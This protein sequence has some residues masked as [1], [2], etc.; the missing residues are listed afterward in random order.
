MPSRA[1][2]ISGEWNGADTGEAASPC[3]R[4]APWPALDRALDRLAMAGDHGLARSVVVGHGADLRRRRRAA[5]IS[6]DQLRV[7]AEEG[8]HGADADRHRLLHQLAAPAHQPHRVGEVES[9]RR[10]PAPSTRRGCARRPRRARSPVRL[11]HAVDGDR[12]GQHRRL[13]VG[14][15]LELGVRPL[16]A[17]PRQ[18]EARARRRPPRRPRAPRRTRRPRPSPCPPS[19]SPGRGTRTPD[20]LIALQT[21]SCGRGVSSALL[22]DAHLGDLLAHPLVELGRAELARP[23]STAFLIALRVRDAV[24]DEAAALDAEQ[25]RGAVLGVVDAVD[26]A[27]RT[28]AWRTGSRAW[29]AQLRS[30]LVARACARSSRPAPRLDLSITLPTKPSQTMTSTEPRNTSRPSTLPTKLRPATP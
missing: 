6:R 26:E 24:A 23:G 9:A 1:G 14:G 3:A 8:R 20:L 5:A 22:E 17:Q 11:E 19:A 13:R 30:H 25:R 28:P 27:A 29:S 2:A 12:H 16:P 7:D 21:T 10:P 18:R 4:R 15:E